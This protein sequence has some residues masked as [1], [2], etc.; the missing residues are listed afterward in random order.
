MNIDITIYKTA[1][2]KLL[3]AQGAQ[4]V[5]FGDLER[6]DGWVRRMLKGEGICVYLR[7]IHTAVRQ[8]LTQHPKN[9]V[10]IFSQIY[11]H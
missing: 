11:R 9:K 10:I 2:G 5:L 7:W 3:I 1:S 8:K 6:R 4:L